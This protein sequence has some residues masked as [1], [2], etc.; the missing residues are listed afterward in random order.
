MYI[1]ISDHW[2]QN[3]VTGQ[4]NQHDPI[5]FMYVDGLGHGALAGNKTATWPEPNIYIYL[6][7]V[8]NVQFTLPQP[9]FHGIN[10]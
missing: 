2:L 3:Q 9:R 5:V 8:A 7:N 1:Y 4:Q 10:Q 6:C